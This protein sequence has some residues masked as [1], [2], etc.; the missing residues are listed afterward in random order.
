MEACCEQFYTDS[1]KLKQNEIQRLKKFLYK[2][3][4]YKFKDNEKTK[5]F[6]SIEFYVSSCKEKTELKD[7]VFS[8]LEDALAMPF[9]VFST[10]QKNKML[11]WFE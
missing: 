10:S 4:N 7:H 3:Q 2:N 8:L 1:K 5:L 6:N 9:T 11:K